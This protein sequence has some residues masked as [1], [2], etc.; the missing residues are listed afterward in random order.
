MLSGQNGSCTLVRV[1][2]ERPLDHPIDKNSNAQSSGVHSTAV[3]YTLPRNQRLAIRA[4]TYAVT[5]D[6][7]AKLASLTG[8]WNGGGISVIFADQFGVE[9][10]GERWWLF[11][12][13]T[14]ATQPLTLG[15]GPTVPQPSRYTGWKGALQAYEIDVGQAFITWRRKAG[16]VRPGT[17][18]NDLANRPG[19]P[20]A[21]DD[22]TIYIDRWFAVGDPAYDD[23]DVARDAWFGEDFTRAMEIA[24]KLIPHSYELF[25]ACIKLELDV[26][27]ERTA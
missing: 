8:S 16:F 17:P 27:Q 9:R 4:K 3:T 13:L 5:D 7:I 1:V 6:G 15:G 10:T 14:G 24:K 21:A 2:P 22:V 19:D 23:L 18:G 26:L 11:D 12:L 25:L 20:R